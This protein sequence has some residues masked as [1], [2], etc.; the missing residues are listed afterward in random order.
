MGQHLAWCIL[1]QWFPAQLL[2][3]RTLL[4]DVLEKEAAGSL[5]LRKHTTDVI[6]TLLISDYRF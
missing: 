6:S 1:N 2:M 3:H 5:V 4:T